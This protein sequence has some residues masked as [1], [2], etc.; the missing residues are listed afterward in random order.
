MRIS[1]DN[2]HRIVLLFF[3]IVDHFIWLYG[4]HWEQASFAYVVLTECIRILVGM[5]LVASFFYP[6]ILEGSVKF[7]LAYCLAMCVLNIFG[8]MDKARNS[9]IPG[10]MVNVFWFKKD[11]CVP[12]EY[13]FLALVIYSY[14]ILGAYFFSG[15]YINPEIIAKK[16]INRA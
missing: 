1:V 16:N 7:V 6:R 2:R 13:G 15:K 5:A 11:R 3:V 4:G 9:D 12:I 14:F 10:S 8:C